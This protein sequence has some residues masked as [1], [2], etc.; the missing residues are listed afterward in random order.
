[1]PSL[2]S[3]RAWA[4]V[5]LAAGV[6]S[7]VGSAGCRQETILLAPRADTTHTGGT[8]GGTLQRVPLNL[9]IKIFPNHTGMG[10]SLG[11]PRRV[12]PGGAGTLHRD[13]TSVSTLHTH[14]H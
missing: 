7:A 5:V 6:T 13:R 10:I 3:V 4:V 11:V 1:M 8:G 12:V 9:T 14:A 2:R